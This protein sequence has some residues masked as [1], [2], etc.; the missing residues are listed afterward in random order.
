MSQRA[1]K[2]ISRN[3]SKQY[4]P[5]TYSLGLQWLHVLLGRGHSRHYCGKKNRYHQGF[6]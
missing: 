5:V 4:S 1:I 6:E 3:N 2:N